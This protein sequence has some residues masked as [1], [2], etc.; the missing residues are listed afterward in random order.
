[1]LVSL[2]KHLS[3]PLKVLGLGP[4]SAANTGRFKM[5]KKFSEFVAKVDA[6]LEINC[7]RIDVTFE[8]RT[9]LSRICLFNDLL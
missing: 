8:M 2:V 4:T 3:H 5:E 1:M 9:V 6:I 7:F